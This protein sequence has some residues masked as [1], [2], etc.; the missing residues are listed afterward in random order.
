MRWRK[1]RT[2]DDLAEE[3]RSHLTLAADRIRESGTFA[4]DSETTARR[5]FGNIT[6]VQEAFYERGRWLLWD[7]LVRDL[8]HAVRL[9]RRKPGFSAVVVLTL[10]LGIGANT[11]IFSLINA[12]LLRPLPYKDPGR[13][14][15]LWT[16]DPA[17]DAHEGRVSLP[18]AHDWQ[19]RNRSFED[20]TVFIGQTFLLGTEGS[21]ERLRS[22][23][24]PANFFP[25]LGVTPA[26]GRVFTRRRRETRRAR[27]GV[28]PRILAAP[29][30]RFTACARR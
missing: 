28:E 18:D 26:A 27:R 24:V 13:L 16:D 8:R 10:A 12:V 7:H 29:V 30:R 5:A 21:P 22:A 1:K 11:A 9:M 2:A 23:R 4:N 20:M 25:M 15:M 3:I 17:D 6:T 19:S 14:A